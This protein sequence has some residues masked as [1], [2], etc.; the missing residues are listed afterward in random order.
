M[1]E[2]PSL[3]FRLPISAG[4]PI[5]ITRGF[6][7]GGA[8]HVQGTV[9]P[10]LAASIRAAADSVLR[11][12]AK[13]AEADRLPAEFEAALARRFVPLTRIPAELT[14][15]DGL[16]S[17]VFREL[18]HD[19]LDKEPELEPNS[20]VRSI[21]LDRADAH[22]PFHQDQTILKRRLLNIWI[23]LDPCGRT[24]PGLEVVW[25]SWR[26]LLVPVPTANAKFPVEFARLDPDQVDDRF[27]SRARWAPEFAVG[28]AMIFAGATIHRT[29]VMSSMRAD[30]MS[31]ELRLF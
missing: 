9:D 3:D 4:D 25:N 19:Y 31:A 17:P 22:L 11:E 23:P 2:E 1:A 24:A 20:H 16:L 30:R 5:A 18:A 14:R 6:S 7:A 26:Q 29:F 27:G 12:W 13:L 8:V 15:L 21:R 10:R 28:D